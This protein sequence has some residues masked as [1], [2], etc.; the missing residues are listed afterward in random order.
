MNPDLELE[1]WR[2]QWQADAEVPAAL[3]RRV[4]A[5]TRHMRLMLAAEL[6]VTVTIGGGSIVWATARPDTEM[7]VLA[8][9]VWIFL[10]IAWAFALATRRGTWSPAAVTTSDFIDLSIRRCR[11]TLGAMRFGIWLYFGEMV[12]CMVWL[13][14][15]PARRTPA[16]AMIF[17]LVTPLFLVG[18]ARYRR[19]VRAELARLKELAG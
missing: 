5:G 19:K 16:P 9:A 4:A 8:I 11:A 6:L 13:Y 12:F 7:V 10:G 3:R 15:D 17:A 14:R 1:N 18:L 2:A